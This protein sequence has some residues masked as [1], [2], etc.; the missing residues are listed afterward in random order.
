MWWDD[1]HNTGL[2]YVTRERWKTKEDACQIFIILDEIDEYMENKNVIQKNKYWN[3]ATYEL[4][5][6]LVI[7]RVQTLVKERLSLPDG[8]G[9][10]QYSSTPC[11]G[12]FRLNKPK[13][14][15][16]LYLNSEETF[17]KR[18]Y[19]DVH[20]TAYTV[21]GEMNRILLLFWWM[22]ILL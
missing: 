22:M 9:N 19:A 8:G 5:W 2:Y 10:I 14:F 21:F 1:S 7:D 4:H 6:D 17:T 20:C 16:H 3:S 13:C 18:S 15:L 12:K 11:L